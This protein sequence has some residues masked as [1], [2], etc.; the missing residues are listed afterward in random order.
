MSAGLIV[1]AA[2]AWMLF[3]VATSLVVASTF[4]G[5]RRVL[6]SLHPATRAI[7]LRLLAVAPVGLATCGLLLCFAPKL[8]VAGVG[9][10]DHCRDHGDP[11]A[12]FCLN[13]PPDMSYG[14]PV[15]VGLAILSGLGFVTLA[16]RGAR[17]RRSSQV[18]RQLVHT[19]RFDSRRR[20]WWV[21]ADDPVALSVGVFRPR[22]LLSKGLARALPDRL[23]TAVLAHEHAHA[24]RRDILWK[25]AA[26]LLS[27]G[28]L[29]GSRRAILTE[30][31]LACEQAC[32]EEAGAALGNRVQVA[33][34]L[35]AMERVRQRAMGASS[36]AL[37]FGEHQL[38]ARVESLIGDAP[39]RR[40][41]RLVAIAVGL[42][43]ALVAILAADPLHHL[44][45][46]LIHHVAG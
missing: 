12:H 33:E 41:E 46:T 7:M 10:V 8:I 2:T 18:L 32:D 43:G 22:T 14:A 23:L 40:G 20:A 26:E 25:L 16:L 3:L 6:R 39:R 31:E 35:L 17:F 30:L 4:A 27:L 45:E 36:A 19:S 42:F 21:D 15:W 24:R 1:L 13:H 34:A 38:T 37:A 29:P 9:S 5:A 11:H 28:H 44:T